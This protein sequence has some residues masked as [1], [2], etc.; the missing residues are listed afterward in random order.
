MVYQDRLETNSLQLFGHPENSECFSII[1]II[2]F[3]IN[4]VDEQ[5]QA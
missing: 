5:K 2:I 4:I 3:E 1:S